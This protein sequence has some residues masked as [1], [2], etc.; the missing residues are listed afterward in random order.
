M[1][2]HE[3]REHFIQSLIRHEN[4]IMA[5]TRLHDMSGI[6]GRSILGQIH[7]SRG[8]VIQ[9]ENRYYAIRVNADIELYG[10]RLAEVVRVSVGINELTQHDGGD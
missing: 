5:L 10:T 2:E 3:A 8:V 4:T 1:T 7:D 9:A 6:D